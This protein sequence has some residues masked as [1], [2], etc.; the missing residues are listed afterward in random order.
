L[1]RLDKYNG[2]LLNPILDELFDKGYITFSD[3]GEI[4]LSEKIKYNPS[5]FLIDSTYTLKKIETK[6]KKYLKYHREN[7]FKK[8]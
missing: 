1:E 4:Q 6:H 7:I 3:N 2:L 8:E 5:K